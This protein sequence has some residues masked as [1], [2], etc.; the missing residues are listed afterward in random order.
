MLSYPKH[1]HNFNGVRGKNLA[2]HR[3]LLYLS[4]NDYFRKS[5]GL[6]INE[7]LSKSANKNSQYWQKSYKYV[8]IVAGF[9]WLRKGKKKAPLKW[10]AFQK[11][12][13][14]ILSWN[15]S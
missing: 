4:F 13:V 14:M 15:Y 7:L 10:A 8:F 9:E 3:N 12:G 6:I 5:K 11:E 1:E 2:A